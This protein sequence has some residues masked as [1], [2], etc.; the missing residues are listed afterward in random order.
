MYQLL[1]SADYKY[2]HEVHC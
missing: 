1:M 2:A